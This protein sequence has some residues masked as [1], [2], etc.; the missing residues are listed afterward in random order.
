MD[1][2]YLILPLLIGGAAS[3]L[4]GINE[5][6]K[7]YSKYAAFA[8]ALGSSI[9]TLIALAYPAMLQ[10]GQ[11][12]WFTASGS[13]SFPLSFS[14]GYI[15]QVLLILVGIISP[16]IFLYSIGY[17]DEPGEQGRYYVELSL[18]AASMILLAVSGGFITF[19]IA[20]EGLG[21][22]SY[23][24]IGFWMQKDAPPYAAR[25]A[26]TTIVIG[27]IMMLSGILL[28]WASLNTF[29]FA[30]I[31]SAIGAMAAVPI[32][33]IVALALII[34]GAF[35]KSAQFPF[36]EWLSDAMEGPTP[37]SAFLHSST[38][39]KAGVFVVIILLPIITHANL[40]WV[41]LVFG[42]ITSI[43]GAFNASGST[44]LKKILAY[45]TI[46]DL[47]LMFVA[48]GLNAVS[49][50]V[51][52][53]IVQAIYKALLFMNAGSIMKANNDEVDIY[54]VSSFSRNRLLFAVGIIGA[55][56]LAGIFPASGF[57]G[58]L[59][60]DSA[61]S[62]NA[63]VYI[64]LTVLDFVTG[65]Y[66]FRWLFIPI[67][68]IGKNGS[69]AIR[70]KYS[71]LSK[72]MLVPQVILAAIAL[73]LTILFLY[74]LT[75][76]SIQ[77]AVI[78]TAA[79]LFGIL[80]AYLLFRTSPN[81]LWERSRSR[82]FL[83][84]GFFVNKAYAYIA[85]GI[86]AIAIGIESIDGAINRLVYVGAEGILRIGNSMRRTGNGIVN[87]YVAALAIGLVLLIAILVF[88]I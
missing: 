33:I 22:T 7:R 53:F 18:F 69:A 81:N 11:I 17:M 87:T 56:S 49:A 83:S 13:I 39:V 59:L 42:I 48:L 52:F 26:I 55:I 20:W 23:L 72:A 34:F 60:I 67:G 4:L 3:L 41:L 86:A 64:I 30:A 74:A 66:I 68:H 78:L 65:F 27:D 25:K 85:S 28:I 15:N 58:K 73:L 1:I 82:E 19:F 70:A 77:A 5:N 50:A 47:G 57:F 63:T 71:A 43:V 61:A 10:Y 6:G 12:A 2:L 79:S 32:S 35:T 29:N 46:E 45:S 38:M 76:V 36:H 51:A 8:G 84:K 75:S 21:I 54:Q 88:V 80:S 24:L 9:L 62:S 44:H 31:I 40:L 14:F 37:V 16:L